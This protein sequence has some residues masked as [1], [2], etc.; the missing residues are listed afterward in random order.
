MLKNYI[1][2]W[3][4]NLVF[5]IILWFIKLNFLIFTSLMDFF[6]S[7]EHG[8]RVIIIYVYGMPINC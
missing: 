8:D 4:T 5:A 2:Y 3:N 7:F 6:Q 1:S